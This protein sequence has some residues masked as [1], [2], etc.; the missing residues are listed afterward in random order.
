MKKLL[1]VELFTCSFRVSGL[2]FGIFHFKKTLL[3]AAGPVLNF[4]LLEFIAWWDPNYTDRFKH[5]L[6]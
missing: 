5:C 4:Y 6:L 2:V 3:T 1:E